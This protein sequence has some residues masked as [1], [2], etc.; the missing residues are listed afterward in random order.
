MPITTSC[1]Q[2]VRYITPNIIRC[3]FVELNDGGVVSDAKARLFDGG[4]NSEP[5]FQL[6]LR[7]QWPHDDY[8]LYASRPCLF[9]FLPNIYIDSASAS[10]PISDSIA[11]T[12]PRQL[13][14]PYWR[15]VARMGRH[16]R[17]ILA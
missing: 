12:P 2:N 10:F 16:T 14:S 6:E 1:I 3:A 5:A 11:E 17:T 13:G 8:A 4:M 15:T 7:R 9:V